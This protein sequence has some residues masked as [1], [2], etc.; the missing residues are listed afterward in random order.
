MNDTVYPCVFENNFDISPIIPN[1]VLK[2]SYSVIVDNDMGHLELLNKTKERL[3]R[4]ISSFIYQKIKNKIST[5][6]K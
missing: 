6:I 3:P 2:S 5:A 1:T 4:E